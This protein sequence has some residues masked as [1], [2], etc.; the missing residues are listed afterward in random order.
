MI[1]GTLNQPAKLL[2]SLG[3]G[4]IIGM[5]YDVTYLAHLAVR[6]K[7]FFIIICDILFFLLAAVVYI[8][9]NYYVVSFDLTIYMICG[10]ITGF[11]LERKSIAI[12]LAKFY[13]KVYNVF[14]INNKEKNNT[15]K[16]K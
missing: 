6:M 15:E 13:K 12:L 11:I 3:V 16:E 1:T 9:V 14:H 7:K 5:L 2:L 10:N 4:I 8:V